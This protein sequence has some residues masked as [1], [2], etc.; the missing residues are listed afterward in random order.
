MALYVGS[1]TFNGRKSSADSIDLEFEREN[2]YYIVA[3]KSGPNW[4]NSRQIA[5]MRDDFRKAKVILR[6]NAKQRAIE[7]INGCCYGREGQEDKGDYLKLCGQSF[8]S[9]L[10]GVESFYIDIIEPIGREAHEP[11]EQVKDLYFG[12]V[13]KMTAEVVE[14]FCD[15]SGLINWPALVRYNSGRMSITRDATAGL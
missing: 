1:A 3:I 12:L 11:N 15:A 9:F 10:S 5:K 2:T 8:W 7:A 6:S 13:N 4:G 14:R